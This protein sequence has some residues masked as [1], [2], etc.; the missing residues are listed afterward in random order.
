MCCAAVGT[1]AAKGLRTEEEQARF[2]QAQQAVLG[3]LL[4]HKRLM[5]TARQQLRALLKAARYS[6][7]WHMCIPCVLP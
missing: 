6:M 7:H 2:L 3:S 5:K 4:S 1:A